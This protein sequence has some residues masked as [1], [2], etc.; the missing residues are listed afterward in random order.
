MFE[1]YPPL[2]IDEVDEFKEIA[3]GVWLPMKWHWVSYDVHY[4]SE[5]NKLVEACRQ[6]YVVEKVKLDTDYADSFFGDV[7]F[8][9]G[10][11]VYELKNG[12]KVK[13]YIQGQTSVIGPRRR[14]S[15][16]WRWL[17]A[18]LLCAIALVVLFVR[19]NRQTAP[20][21]ARAGFTLIELL[22]VI[23]VIGVLVGLLLPAV[24]AAREAARRL[25]CQN[26]LKQLALAA[27]NYQAAIGVYPFG[28]G[29]GGAVGFAGRWSPQS[30][31]LLQMEQTPLY[32]SLNFSFI[33]WGH[34]GA[35]SEINA[36]AL[37]TKIDMFLC[38]SDSDQI[39]EEFGMAHNN[40]RA[41]AG[42]LPINLTAGSLRGQGGNNGVFWYQSSLPPAPFPTA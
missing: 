11:A 5:D 18:G 34:F 17:V 28:S 22:V 16:L 6:D 13:S 23:V 10:T 35:M 1:K 25:E 26:H 40:Y 36:T 39:I 31:L 30:Q 38:P 32:H 2:E 3:P 4:L 37:G 24:Q 33:P 29:G 12:K 21:R 9:D 27:N 14:S 42:T 41:C 7:P 19:R 8:P 15:G 20:A